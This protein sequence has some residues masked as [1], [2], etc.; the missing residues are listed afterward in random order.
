MFLSPLIQFSATWLYGLFFEYAVHRWILHGPG[1]KKSS[2]VSFHF[3]EHHAIA[4]R[5]NMHDESYISN[6]WKLN[7]K[8][9]ELIALV[10]AFTVHIPIMIALPWVG[11]AVFLSIV[12]YFFQHA[13]SH[14]NVEWGR[15]ALSWH[16]DHHMGPDQNKNFGVRTDF[17]DKL[18][19]TR[20]IYYGTRTER[21]DYHRRL[22][23][24]AQHVVRKRSLRESRMR[25]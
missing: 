25:E 14:K 22:G 1:R 11:L 12:S 23:K 5:R 6:K 20:R 19:G 10:L 4:R 8:T 16:Y 2:I 15:V 18:F 7:S 9:K 3:H 21:I 17:F 13:K 24:Y